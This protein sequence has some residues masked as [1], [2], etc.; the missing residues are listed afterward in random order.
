M[1]FTGHIPS[2]VKIGAFIGELEVEEHRWLD[3]DE[4]RKEIDRWYGE[5]V[6]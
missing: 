4:Y 6:D 2:N 5:E 1:P 3:D